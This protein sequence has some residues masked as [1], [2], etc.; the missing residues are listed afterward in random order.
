MNRKT[1]M[2]EPGSAAPKQIAPGIWQVGTISGS[3]LI[4]AED[5]EEIE[6]FE[7][8]CES[9]LSFESIQI[10][11]IKDRREGQ[12]PLMRRIP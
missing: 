6:R 1:V 3:K 8:D 10:R 12:A 7:R 4:F 2:P 5:I 9:I 11:A